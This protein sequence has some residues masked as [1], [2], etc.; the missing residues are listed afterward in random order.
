MSVAAIVMIRLMPRWGPDARSRL[1]EAA[2][3]LYAQRGFEATTVAEIAATAGLTERTFFRYFVDKREVLF[4]GSDQLQE[5]IVG[6]VAAAPASDTPIEAVAAGLEVAG[7]FFNAERRDYS[8][9]RQAVI[10]ANPELRER[11]LVKLA[12]LGSA[13]AETLRRRGVSDPA[14]SLCAEAGMGV[15]RVAFER[16]VDKTVEQD[17][18]TLVEESLAGLKELIAAH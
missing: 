9:R 8:R 7:T 10:V 4:A 12:S 18:S 2:M 17:W 11:E 16:W 3:Q 6:A 14:A 1:R 15:F 5:A 13:L